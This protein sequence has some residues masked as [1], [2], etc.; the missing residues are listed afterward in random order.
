ML[1]WEHQCHKIM[2]LAFHVWWLTFFF[3]L[4]SLHSGLHITAILVGQHLANLELNYGHDKSINVGRKTLDLEFWIEL[5]SRGLVKW[6][7]KL[8]FIDQLQWSWNYG[9]DLTS[10]EFPTFPVSTRQR[11]G[12]TLEHRNWLI[13]KFGTHALRYPIK[14]RSRLQFVKF[15]SI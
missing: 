8:P 2:S 12:Y 9:E 14:H 7:N 6:Y 3:L 1:A 15:M 5:P 10:R 11:V 4:A 13:I